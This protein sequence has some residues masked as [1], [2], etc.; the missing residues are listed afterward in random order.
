MR[1]SSVPPPCVTTPHHAADKSRAADRRSRWDARI[2]SRPATLR[3]K[4]PII[5]L[6]KS[7]H[8]LLSAKQTHTNLETP[9]TF[10]KTNVTRLETSVTR[11]VPFSPPM[12]TFRA[13]PKKSKSKQTLHGLSFPGGSQNRRKN[14]A[15][16][17]NEHDMRASRRQP[18]FGLEA[19]REPA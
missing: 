18:L 12:L 14:S 3:Y 13:F 17:L 11:P 10:L 7:N 2:P 15:P 1:L 16:P 5:S 4:T 8:P 9:V 6:Q 19:A